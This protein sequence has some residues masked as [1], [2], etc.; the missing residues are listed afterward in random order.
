MARVS[1][2]G[3]EEARRATKEVAYNM[4]QRVR[5]ELAFP[6]V[7]HFYVWLLHG[8]PAPCCTEHPP[9]SASCPLLYSFEQLFWQFIK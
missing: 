4:K 8:Q 5:Q 3:Q 6:A 7:V 1:R 9:S 2:F